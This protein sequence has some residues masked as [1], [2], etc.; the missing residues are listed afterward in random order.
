EPMGEIGKSI[1]RGGT[2][3]LLMPHKSQTK[4]THA[5]AGS[6]A[7]VQVEL[8]DGKIEHISEAYRETGPEAARARA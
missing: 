2:V 6:Q 5:L 8:W 1:D 3:N 7:L 4:S